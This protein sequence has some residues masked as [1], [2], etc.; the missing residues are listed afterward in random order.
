MTLK[1]LKTFT[2]GVCRTL[3][4][5]DYNTTYVL[6]NCLFEHAYVIDIEVKEIWAVA[7]RKQFLPR[8]DQ[9]EKKREVKKEIQNFLLRRVRRSAWYKNKQTNKLK[10]GKT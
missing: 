9:E 8:Q 5:T 1:T 7:R 4:K 6:S 10:T 2:E 3:V